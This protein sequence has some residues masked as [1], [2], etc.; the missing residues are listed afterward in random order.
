M[1]RHIEKIIL[2]SDFPTPFFIYD[3]SKIKKQFAKLNKALPSNI[4]IFYS[5][6]TNPS[7][8]ILKFIRRLGLGAEIT[9]AGE[10]LAVQEVG[11]PSEKIIF[12]GPGKTNEE[13]E[14]AIR[15]GIYLIIAESLKEMERIERISQNL[16]KNQ[17]ILIRI[18][19]SQ[20]I[21]S[22]SYKM[23][24][25]SQ[26]FG[27]DE[28]MVENIILRAPDFKNT[29]LLGIHFYGASGVLDYNIILENIKIFL[30]LIKKIE[31]ATKFRFSII[32][33]G[34][35][36]GVNSYI[37]S[38]VDKKNDISDFGKALKILLRTSDFNNRKIILEIGRFLVAEAG[39]YITKIIDIKES[40]GRKFVIVDGGMNHLARAGLEPESHCI[41]II[42]R[43]YRNAPSE[44]VDIA[45]PLAT[46]TDILTRNALL[47]KPAIGDLIIINKAGAYG[48]TSGMLYFSTRPLPAEYA[49]I[50]GKLVIIRKRRDEKDLFIDQIIPRSY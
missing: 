22:G 16:K 9:S 3:F 17:N 4:N 32:D 13:L 50:D 35:G 34:L 2:N 48:F 38:G 40:R 6:K 49:L 12:T 5:V 46:P 23:S 27:V 37:S 21:K 39:S 10:L 1:T 18:N 45:G 30:N 7:L 43:N 47:P 42:K 20:F 29:K 14:K 25:G 31:T 41:S 15:S 8:A 28:E 11:F 44:K 26:K 36:L 19:L 24:G 33:M